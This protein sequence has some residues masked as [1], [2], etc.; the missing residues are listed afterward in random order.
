MD[1]KTLDMLRDSLECALGEIAK[2]ADF[3]PRDLEHTTKLLCAIEMVK[4]LRKDAEEVKE[5]TP[6]EK[7]LK[8]FKHM[9]EEAETEQ[10]RQV[11]QE[12]ID[13]LEK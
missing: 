7:M 5:L 4:R 6:Q 11:V 3:T 8:K 2:K 12:W 10:E 1:A 13:R 9:L